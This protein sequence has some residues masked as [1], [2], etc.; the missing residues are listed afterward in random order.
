MKL[1]KNDQLV[2]NKIVRFI[3]VSFGK[4]RTESSIL[5]SFKEIIKII[6]FN[7]YDILVSILMLNRTKKGIL[8]DFLL[9]ENGLGVLE[10]N[11]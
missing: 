9:K 3:E 1:K 7:F 4:N 11:L 6:D 10:K 5:N 2:L 8:I